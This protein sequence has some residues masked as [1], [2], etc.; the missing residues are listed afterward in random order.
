MRAVVGPCPWSPD[1]PLFW[2]LFEK[3]RDEKKNGKKHT[4]TFVFYTHP[5]NTKTNDV[6]TM[7]KNTKKRKKERTNEMDYC[8]R[9]GCISNS[10]LLYTKR[11]DN[12][13]TIV[14]RP[15]IGFEY[16]ICRI[17]GYI[18]IYGVSRVI[19]R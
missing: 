13:I 8:K 14:Y 5:R 3:K 2:R 6:K 18:C 7:R 19:L 4:Q 12:R 1:T 10:C 16:S 11:D 15:R 9:N 17:D